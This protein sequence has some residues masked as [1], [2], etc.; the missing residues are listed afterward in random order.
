MHPAFGYADQPPL[1]PLLAAGGYA[2]GHLTWIVRIPEILAAAAL[3]WITVAFVRLLG[4]KDVAAALAALAVTVAP[5]I[6]G[7]AATL[8]TTTFEPLAWTAVAYLLA[9]LALLDDRRAPLVAGAIAG[10]ALEAKDLRTTRVVARPRT[11]DRNYRAV[12][13][14]A[15]G[16]RMAVSRTRTQCA[17]Q[18]CRH[19][20]RGF[21]FSI[22]SSSI[23]HCSRPFG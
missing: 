1:V 22:R 6:A 16:A 19:R 9:R 14:L 23:R 4:G 7:V 15:S 21:F 8:N 2:L 13:R 11:R 20:A 3:A 5:E 12:A 10:F 17:S 18:G